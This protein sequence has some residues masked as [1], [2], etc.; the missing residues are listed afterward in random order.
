MHQIDQKLQYHVTG[1]LF[2]INVVLLNFK[3]SNNFQNVS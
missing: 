1:N 3:S 2:Q